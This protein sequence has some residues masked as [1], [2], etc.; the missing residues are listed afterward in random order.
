MHIKDYHASFH[1][2]STDLRNALKSGKHWWYGKH[3][4]RSKPTAAMNQ[5]SAV[6]S[7]IGEPE[8]FNKEFAVKPEGLN[9]GSKEG[10]IWKKE[11]PG[12]IILDHAF[13]ESLQEIEK[14]FLESPGRRYYEMEGDTEFTFMWTQESV[15]AKC[16]PDW[17]SEDRKIIVDLKTTQDASKRG[18]QRSIG[19]YGYHIQAAWYCIGA[20]AVTGVKTEE[21]TFIAIEKAAPYGIGVYKADQEMLEIGR[22]KCQ[23]ALAMIATWEDL[24]IFPDYSEGVELISLPPWMRPKKDVTPDSDHEIELY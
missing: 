15:P 7:R 21:F 3:G 14:A 18:F 8:S 1:N 5:G 9:L 24:Q 17:I 16:R 2:G 19:T 10:K 12:K 11:N 20:E 23:E 6:H 4:P 13:G 22:E